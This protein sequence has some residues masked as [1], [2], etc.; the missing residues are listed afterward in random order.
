M[1][2]IPDPKVLEEGGFTLVRGFRGFTPWSVGFIVSRLWQ[3]SAS[4]Q[5]GLEKQSTGCTVSKKQRGKGKELKTRFT[6][7]DMT[8]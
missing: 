5:M 6:S 1:K 7:N 3:D 8:T 4:Q 2:K